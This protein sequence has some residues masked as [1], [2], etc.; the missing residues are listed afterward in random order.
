MGVQLNIDYIRS[1]RGLILTA[2]LAFGFIGGIIAVV[3]SDHF[4]SFCLWSTILISG[5]MLVLNVLKAYRT[6]HDKFSFL[7]FVELGY[8]AM[9]VLF[10]VVAAIITAVPG[11]WNAGS[12]F[13]YI[14]LVLFILDGYLYFRIYKEF[15]A[16]KS[17]KS[18]PVAADMQDQFSI[19]DSF[20]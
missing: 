16:G 9:W 12:V 7:I 1:S 10:Y 4:L 15:E 5:I 3:Y 8:I 19:D 20:Y 6:L 17:S 2:E 11:S 14:E 13:G 18:H